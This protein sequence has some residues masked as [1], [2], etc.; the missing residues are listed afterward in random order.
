MATF[1]PD[2]SQLETVYQQN[3]ADLF[4]LCYLQGG[5]PAPT[6]DLMAAT[7]CDIASSPKL[8]E[9]ALSSREGFL[10]VGYLNCVD[11][12]LRR[13]KRRKKKKGAPLEDAP[14]AVLPFFL[15]D[16]LRQILKLRLHLGAAL[17]CR[18]RLGFSDDSAAA[19]LGCTPARAKKLYESALKK[20]GVTQVQSQA[21]LKTLAPGEDNL[22]KVWQ[23]FLVQRKDS[24]FGA[25]QQFRRFRRTMD[26]LVPY[27]ALGVVVLCVVAFV[28]VDRGWF[29]SQNIPSQQLESQLT[30]SKINT[31]LQV[32][33]VSVFVPEDQGF[34]EYTVHNTPQ[35]LEELV[36]QMVLLGGAP[37]GT[38]LLSSQMDNGGVQSTDGSTVTYTSGDAVSLT[39]ELSE[40]ASS[41]S[42][43]KGEQM[44]Q[45]MTATF[46]AFRPEI[47]SLSLRCGGEELT[48]N[49][50][51]AQDFL[52]Q[53]PNVTRSAET[54]YRE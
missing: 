33:D 41:L 26:N 44:L 50:K 4:A 18:D 14:R 29:G 11:A 13:P 53:S 2:L 52:G 31:A 28:G 21:N 37:T 7:L 1:N 19:V 9:L 17:L 27:L 51:T 48:V 40:E 49:G 3:G 20:A 16:P 6:L 43:E 39:V 46:A 42:G 45:A 24:G 8:W 34:V 5:R 54:D 30:N 38:T 25:R 23:E 12:S 35:S 36:R 47:Q 10:R 22:E 15:T 32:G